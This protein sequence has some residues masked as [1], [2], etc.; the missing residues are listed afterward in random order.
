[1]NI[2]KV[3]ENIYKTY[4]EM[5]YKELMEVKPKILDIEELERTVEQTI[6]KFT[7]LV[8]GWEE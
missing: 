1:M 4:I 3:R 5:M 2:D 8:H 6:N 7:N